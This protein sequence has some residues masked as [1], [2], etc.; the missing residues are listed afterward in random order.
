M[1]D[2]AA[3]EAA[4]DAG[5]LCEAAGPLVERLQANAE[6]YT[7]E[8]QCEAATFIA[9]ARE[10]WPAAIGERDATLAEVARLREAGDEVVVA[11]HGF[12]LAGCPACSGDCASANPPVQNCP[13]TEASRVVRNWNRAAIKDQDNG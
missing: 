8:L 6:D 10:G 2:P 3:I 9:A 5:E 11:I 13:M 7:G 1:T 4:L 12:V